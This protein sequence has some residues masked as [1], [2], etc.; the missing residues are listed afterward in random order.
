[1]AN[2]SR[3][4]I[5]E[6]DHSDSDNNT[7][8]YIADSHCHRHCDEDLNVSLTNKAGE[9]GRVRLPHPE[10]SNTSNKKRW[11]NEVSGRPTVTDIGRKFDRIVKIF[12]LMSNICHKFAI[13]Y[14]S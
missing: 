4:N 9:L 6:S 8:D 12:T 1:M 7:I 5:I 11:R 2:N 3:N 13:K 10:L 14:V